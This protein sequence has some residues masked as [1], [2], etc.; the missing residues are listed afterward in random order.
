MDLPVLKT[1]DWSRY[2]PELIMAEDLSVKTV[3]GALTC[4]LVQFLAEQGYELCSRLL[5]TMVFRQTN[6][7]GSVRK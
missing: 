6:T 3:A 2:R 1:N 4:P 7:D 5:H